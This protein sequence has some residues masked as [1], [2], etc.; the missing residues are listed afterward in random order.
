MPSDNQQ[1]VCWGKILETN[2]LFRITHPYVSGHLS[3]QLVAIHA[4]FASLD[5]LVFRTKDE[6]V[7]RTKLEWWRLEIQPENIERSRHPVV[8]YLR[9]SGV[10]AGLN[11]GALSN[12]IEVTDRQLEAKTLADKNEFKQFCRDIYQPRIEIE[13]SL[14]PGQKLPLERQQSMAVKGGLILLMEGAFKNDPGQERTLWWVPLSLL[15][16]HQVSRGELMQ[17]LGSSSALSVFRELLSSDPPS[18]TSDCSEPQ[19]SV[20]VLQSHVH[21]V[22]QDCLRGRQIK[23]LQNSRPSEFGESLRRLYFMDVFC[24]WRMARKSRPVGN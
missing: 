15:A 10:A 13:A 8:G 17:N 1:R 12:L 5:L 4:L 20:E 9:E 24:L 11:Q 16:R 14:S 21:L 2:H 23:R 7:A 19:E 6:G 18:V 22:L 3:E